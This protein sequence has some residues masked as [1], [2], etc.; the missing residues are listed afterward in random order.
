MSNS[1][2]PGSLLWW[3]MRSRRVRWRRRRGRGLRLWVKTR[4][5][6]QRRS[7]ELKT[8]CWL[9]HSSPQELWSDV[10]KH[11]GYLNLQH[12]E[13]DE[14]TWCPAL[15]W[16]IQNSSC[17]KI[18]PVWVTERDRSLRLDCDRLVLGSDG[19][20]CGNR[21]C[22]EKGRYK[23]TVHIVGNMAV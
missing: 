2:S 15:L 4:S 10:A 6:P 3:M 12:L 9:I 23:L 8:S 5:E 18:W 22:C 20:Q 1:N 21:G 16:F 14:G 17:L 13:P 11:L 19:C 7:W